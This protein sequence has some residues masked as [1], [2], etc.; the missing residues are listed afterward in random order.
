[1]PIWQAR[2]AFLRACVAGEIT[3]V[4]FLRSRA[5]CAALAPRMASLST[6]GVAGV[7]SSATAAAA[8]ATATG[9]TAGATWL[10]EPKAAMRPVS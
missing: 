3:R 4:L 2:L 7:V 8:S 10:G 1:M 5:S 9:G 6:E